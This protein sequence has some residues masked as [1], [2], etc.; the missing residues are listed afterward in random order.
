MIADMNA[1]FILRKDIFVNIFKP[2]DSII[3]TVK[4]LII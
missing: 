1:V 2:T 3:L 4:K